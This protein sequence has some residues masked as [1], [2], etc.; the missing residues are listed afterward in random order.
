MYSEQDLKLSTV[1]CALS[2]NVN[3][4]S[5]IL[6]VGAV[7]FGQAIEMGNSDVRCCG[8]GNYTSS[9]VEWQNLRLGKY[10]LC[11]CYLDGLA[12]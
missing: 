9:T 10:S 1:N 8:L 12:S 6:Q 3:M 2:E 4:I 11:Q 5:V 7:P